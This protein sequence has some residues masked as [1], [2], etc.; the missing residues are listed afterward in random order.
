MTP[1]NIKRAI[2]AA[3]GLS[4]LLSWVTAGPFTVTGTSTRDGK[5][6]LLLGVIGFAFTFR[7][8]VTW[9][10]LIDSLLA[11]GALAFAIHSFVQVEHA[12][13]SF[14]GRLFGVTPGAGLFIATIATGAW[15]GRNA[16]F[17][18]NRIKAGQSIKS[19]MMAGQHTG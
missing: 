11:V 5:I 19:V 16:W 2:T 4:P 1:L 6:V 8:D 10:R 7:P 18:G 13:S 15:V 14:G 12:S 3:V 9:G 17:I